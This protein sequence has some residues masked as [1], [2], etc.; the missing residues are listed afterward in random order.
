MADKK[1]K[2]KLLLIDANSLIHRAF[3]ALPPLTGPG[4]KPTGALYGLASILIKLFNEDH[5][6]Y[7]VAAFDRPEPTF[8]DDMYDEYKA[9]RPP[10]PDTLVDQL[11]EARVLMEHFGI[12]TVEIPGYEADDLIATLAVK[13][14]NSDLQVEIMSGDLDIL[15]VVEGDRIVAQVPKKGISETTIYNENQVK[16]R[17][18]VSPE[19]L[20]DYK[21]LVGDTSDNIPGVTGIGPKS[22]VDLIIRYTDIE[23]IYAHLAEIKEDKPTLAQKLEEGKESALLSKKLAT[24]ITDVPV[25]ETLEALKTGDSLK[26]KDLWKYLEGLGFKTLINRIKQ[27]QQQASRLF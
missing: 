7:A 3:H 11:K 12:K 25:N 17:F 8:R 5:P 23:N 19:A 24:L 27:S 22:A 4:G 13:F 15:Q 21:G 1:M 14:S 10:T 26:N 16:E 20:A 2:D 18:G 6:L 9:T